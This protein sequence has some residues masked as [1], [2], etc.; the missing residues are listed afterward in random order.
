MFALEDTELG[1]TGLVEHVI[2]T[3]EAKPVKTSPG[4]LPYVLRKEPEDELIKLE[5]TGC[6]E[7]SASPYASGLVLVSKKDGTLRV[8][9][10]Y[11]QVNKDTVADRYPM[12]RVDELVDAIGRREGKYFT[13]VDLMKG[14]HQVKMEEQSKPKTAFTCHLGLYQYR[15]MPFGLTN[16][17]ATFRD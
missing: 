7:P 17:P 3:G 15:R 13:T 2:D 1:E 4:R 10:D 14:Y 16:A 8:C 11:R 9:V 12:P 5:T 6:I